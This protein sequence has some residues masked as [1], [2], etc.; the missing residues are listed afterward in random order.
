M[1]VGGREGLKAINLYDNISFRGKPIHKCK[2]SDIPKVY[3]L[4]EDSFYK[5]FTGTVSNKH[6]TSTIK[7]NKLYTISTT[8][9]LREY[10]RNFDPD[11]RMR[12]DNFDF[13]LF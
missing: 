11:M 5:S 8:Y 12:L 6:Y 3:S 4:L 1:N 13:R 10:P 2:E 9:Y 7:H